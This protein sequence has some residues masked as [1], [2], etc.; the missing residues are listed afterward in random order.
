VGRPVVRGILPGGLA[1]IVS[2]I[3][4]G[5]TP[6]PPAPPVPPDAPR[7]SEQVTVTAER[8]PEERGVTPAAVSVLTREEIE[9]IPAENLAELLDALPGIQALFAER[10]SGTLPMVGARGFFGGGEAEYVQ[11][12]VDGVPVGDAES[13]IADWR[14]IRASDIDRIEL[15][16]GPAS[17]LYGDTALAGVVQVFTRAA[18][19]GETEGRAEISAGSFGSAGAEAR[20]AGFAGGWSVAASGGAFRTDGFRAHSAAEETEGRLSAQRSAGKSSWSLRVEGRSTDREEPG[21]LSRE[22]RE[23]R[24][25][26][27]DPVFRLDREDME[28]ARAAATYR[29]EGNVSVRAS[30]AAG[31]R[32]SDFV[33]TLLLAPGFGDRALRELSSAHV[34]GSVEAEA[35]PSWLRPGRL[36]AGGEI[37]REWLDTAYRPVSEGGAAGAR[38]G[39]ARGF[40]D[41]VGVFLL[42]EVNASR[43]VRATAG[44]RWDLLEEDFGASNSRRQAWSPRLGINV[45]IGPL[46]RSPTS[47]FLVASRAF[48]APTLDQLYDPRPFPDFQGGTFQLSN[49]AL[50]PQ[51]AWNLELGLF[52][53]LPR[54]RLD[55]SLYWMDVEDEIDFDPASLRY[56]NIGD[57]LHEGIEASGRIRLAG[58]VWTSVSYAWTRAEP[59]Q[60]EHRGRQLKNIPEH[61]GRAALEAVLPGAVRAALSWSF[62]ARRYLDDA[63]AFPLE[64][65]STFD[66]RLEREAGRW[67]IRVDVSNLTDEEFPQ[68]GFVLPASDGTGALFEYPA[69]GLSA[70]AG[71]EWR[72]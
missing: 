37:A 22:D 7:V 27:S 28:R 38:S 17:S 18:R 21:A 23:R 40:R 47:V 68:L 50:R 29:Y 15:L 10:W 59:R 71:L 52:R 42:Q 13:G 2:A 65:A 11:L 1:L 44:A 70:R 12:R 67:T 33:R 9:R 39:A 4:A 6:P 58:R 14:G 45:R 31:S 56:L 25:E 34:S 55:L 57:S 64:D 19:P 48:K 63:N 30:L 69:P 8:A 35:A 43:R 62:M 16:R 24:P 53:E 32:R 26:T 5:Q 54:A 60:G 61:M 3:G 49:P 51:R 66:L 72:F 46:D 36:V 41:R 20:W